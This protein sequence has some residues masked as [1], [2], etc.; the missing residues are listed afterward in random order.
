MCHGTSKIDKSVHIF[1]MSLLPSVIVSVTLSLAT[2]ITFVYLES[3][4][5]ATLLLSCANYD[6]E[7]CNG[8]S[9][10]SISAMSSA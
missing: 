1:M 7:N 5:S 6:V 8:I 3:T 10:S 4:V 2:G 9:G